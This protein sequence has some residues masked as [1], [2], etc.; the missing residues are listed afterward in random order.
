MYLK[1][2]EVFGWQGF[3]EGM[4]EGKSQLR[5]I[6]RDQ[7]LDG[8][9]ITRRMSPNMKGGIVSVGLLGKIVS[10]MTF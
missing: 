7:S 3:K 8:L 9:N 5:S 2:G 6:Q 1:E 10:E 4:K